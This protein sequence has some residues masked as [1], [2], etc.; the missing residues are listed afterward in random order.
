MQTINIS[1]FRANLLQY[2]EVANA[3]EEISVTSNG[4]LLA[5][6]VPPANQKE[7]VKSQLKHLAQTANVTD[8]LSPIDAEWDAM[9]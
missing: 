5:T 6:I 3:G 2:L 8:V 7:Q 9:T 4:R 1:Q